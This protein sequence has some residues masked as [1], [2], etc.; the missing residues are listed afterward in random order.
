[1]THHNHRRCCCERSPAELAKAFDLQCLNHSTINT[2]LSARNCTQSD[3]CM[4]VSSLYTWR[5]YVKAMPEQMQN[6]AGRHSQCVPAATHCFDED[7]TRPN[8]VQVTSPP[9]GLN[10][11]DDAT[12]SSCSSSGGNDGTLTDVIDCWKV[13]ILMRFCVSINPKNNRKRPCD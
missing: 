6:A 2:S 12:S 11:I 7:A 9:S 8:A 13:C 10:T 3:L 4:Y 5:A 1:M